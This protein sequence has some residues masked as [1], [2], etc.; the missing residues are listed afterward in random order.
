MIEEQRWDLFL[1]PRSCRVPGVPDRAV[2]GAK[3]CQAVSWGG[4][5]KLLTQLEEHRMTND[6]I[7][8]T[9]HL[10]DIRGDGMGRTTG[11]SIKLRQRP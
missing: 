9:Y 1:G 8:T 7:S 4:G 11:T 10:T 2:S 3:S 5:Y 6:H